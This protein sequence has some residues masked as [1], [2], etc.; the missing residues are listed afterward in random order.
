MDEYI[1]VFD[2]QTGEVLYKSK[3]EAGGYAAPVTYLGEDGKQYIVIC[4]GGGGKLGTKHGDYV[5]AFRL[6]E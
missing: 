4:A 6:P 3:L 1:R 5:I 2:E